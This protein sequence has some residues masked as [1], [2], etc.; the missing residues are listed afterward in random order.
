MVIVTLSM[1]RD[2][3]ARFGVLVPVPLQGAAGSMLTAVRFVFF[4]CW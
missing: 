3:H 1:G 4:L 2:A